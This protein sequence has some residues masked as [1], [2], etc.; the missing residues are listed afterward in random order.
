MVVSGTRSGGPAIRPGPARVVWSSPARGPV[1]SGSARARSLQR[2]RSAAS[3]RAA[4]PACAPWLLAAAACLQA[5]S[6]PAT[7]PTNRTRRRALWYWDSLRDQAI[8][9]SIPDGHRV[10][11]RDADWLAWSPDGHFVAAATRSG[12]AVSTWPG[13]E[14]MALFPLLAHDVV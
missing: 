8:A 3:S 9:L 7:T 13:G 6:H 4:R 10:G 14:R 5:S 2:R 11:P 12:L 1:H